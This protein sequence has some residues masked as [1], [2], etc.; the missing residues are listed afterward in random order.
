VVP[1]V[2][3]YLSGKVRETEAAEEALPERAVAEA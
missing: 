2:Y 3:T 1:V